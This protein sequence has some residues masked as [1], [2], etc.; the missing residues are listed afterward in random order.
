MKLKAY[1][2]RSLEELAPKIREELG[3]NA[4]VLSQRQNVRGGVGGFFGTRTIEVLAADRMPE[5][6][7]LPA[8][9][10]GEA[11]PA[12]EP[13]APLAPEPATNGLDL[14]DRGDDVADLVAAALAEASAA[15]E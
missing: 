3:P 4:V 10:T 2:G 5:E 1:V 8:E 9:V 13:E 7:E 14:V 6:G 15:R 12:V 11:R